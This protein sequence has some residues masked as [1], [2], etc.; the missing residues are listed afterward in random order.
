[1]TST[2]VYP[3]VSSQ[4]HLHGEKTDFSLEKCIHVAKVIYFSPQLPVGP[5]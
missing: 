1:M 2:C 4:Q 5:V 3:G